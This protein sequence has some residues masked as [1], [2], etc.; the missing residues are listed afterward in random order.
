MTKIR[1]IEEVQNIID[2]CSDLINGE[3]KTFPLARDIDTDCFIKLSGLI[4]NKNNNRTIDIS[5][6]NNNLII[7]CPKQF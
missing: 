3:R 5:L 6:S 2:N 7:E 4:H 1:K